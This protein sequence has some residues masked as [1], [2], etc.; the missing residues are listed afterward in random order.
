M[1]MKKTLF[2]AAALAVAASPVFAQVVLT[3]DQS[4]LLAG[5]SRRPKTWM[6]KLTPA[7]VDPKPISAL[8]DR[9]SK[10]GTQIQTEE[11]RIGNV[12]GR[13]GA[14]DA[15]GRFRGVEAS[16]VEIPAEDV[17]GTPD[18]P[19]R[20]LV[21]RRYFSRLEATSDDWRVNPDTGVGRVDEWHYVVSLAG[22]LMSVEHTIVPI[23]PVG[24][25]ETAPVLE[26]A[27][28]YR[29]A[30][31]DAAVQKRWKKFSR[32]LLTLGKTV[33]A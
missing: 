1:D 15:R 11:G 31:S 17:E 19:I 12:L 7:A 32:E 25:G 23:E 28:A 22:R 4:E 14:P 16:L 20:D 24:P 13:Q 29:M 30:P 3:S 2:F 10:D 18:S 27:R 21:M 26:K 9:L 33:E 5:I 6:E 8:M